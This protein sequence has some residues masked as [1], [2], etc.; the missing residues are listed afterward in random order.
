MLHAMVL[1]TGAHVPCHGAGDWSSCSMP[2]CWRL[3]LMFHA[4]V[5]ETGAL[6]S[7]I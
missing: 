4:M 2:W 5:L 1:E 7:V 3:E 6:G